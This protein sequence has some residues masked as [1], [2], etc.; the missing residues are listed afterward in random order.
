MSSRTDQPTKMSTP[1]AVG[2]LASHA[3]QRPHQAWRSFFPLRSGSH[4]Q[5]S[6]FVFLCF[7]FLSTP[8][9]SMNHPSTCPEH[10]NEE[11][12]DLTAEQVG[13]NKAS[14]KV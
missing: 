2:P 10:D 14:G 12:H 4:N 5:P 11:E 3:T 7:C 1:A 6:F 8:S 13:N 9:H